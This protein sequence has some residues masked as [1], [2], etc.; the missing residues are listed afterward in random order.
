MHLHQLS[1]TVLPSSLAEGMQGREVICHRQGLREVGLTRYGVCAV[2]GQLHVVL[3]GDTED[4]LDVA[5]KV[6][7][8]VGPTLNPHVVHLWQPHPISQSSVGTKPYLLSDGL[9]AP[10]ALCLFCWTVRRKGIGMGMDYYIHLAI[11]GDA[12][13]GA[14]SRC[15]V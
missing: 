7:V 8:A 10:Q 6:P 2:E 13:G 14:G 9:N 1:R 3:S 12:H 5:H 4:G 11:E 15:I